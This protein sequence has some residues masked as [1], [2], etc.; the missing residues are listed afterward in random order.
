[1][2]QGAKCR[3]WQRSLTP[4]PLKTQCVVDVERANMSAEKFRVTVTDSDYD[5]DQLVGNTMLSKWDIVSVIIYF[6]LVMAAG[7]YV[8]IFLK[9]YFHSRQAC[10]TLEIDLLDN[11]VHVSLS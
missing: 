5:N 4:A 9:C 8:S 7:L 1:M 11:I 3:H 2:R 10:Q 6:I